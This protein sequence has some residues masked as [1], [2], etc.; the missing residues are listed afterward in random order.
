[1]S[2]RSSRAGTSA[3][4]LLRV[5]TRAV[6]LARSARNGTIGVQYDFRHT[7]WTRVAGLASRGW[8]S[9]SVMNRLLIVGA[10]G[11]GREVLDAALDVPASERDW[12]V[13]GFLDDRVEILKGKN[14]PLPIVGTPEAYQFADEDRVVCAIGDPRTRLRYCRQLQARGARFASVIHPTAIVGFNS[15]ISEGCILCPYSGISNNVTLGNYVVLNAYSGVGHDATIAEGC[16]LSAYVNVNGWAV[17]GE[18]VFLGSHAVVL[19]RATV[20]DYA[21]VGAGSVV[22]KKVKAGATVFGV[23]AVEM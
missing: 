8:R 16:T 7:I 23:P 14:C 10:G 2:F 22:L 11:F 19:P 6:V 18:G 4:H 9:S 3:L 13:A 5:M 15:R 20:G 12:D 21:V 17:L 1:M